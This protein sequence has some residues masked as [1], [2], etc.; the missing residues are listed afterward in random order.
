[1]VLLNSLKWWGTK[2]K[3][4]S[5]VKNLEM[6]FTEAYGSKRLRKDSQDAGL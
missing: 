3:V 5:K 4:G 1:M 2:D 6:L